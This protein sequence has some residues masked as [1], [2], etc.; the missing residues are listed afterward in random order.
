MLVVTDT[1]MEVGWLGW[2]LRPPAPCLVLVVKATYSLEEQGTCGLAEPQ[3]PLTGD[4]YVDD[5]PERSLVYDSD[6]AILK[7][8][9]EVLL[10][11]TCYPAGL[12]PNGPGVQSSLVQLR[13]GALRCQL[14]VLGDRWWNRGLLGGVSAPLPFRSMPLGWERAFG[15]P[16]DPRNPVGVG[17]VPDPHDAEGRV[18][19]PNI[20]DPARLIRGPK[21]R[22]TPAGLFPISKTWR[23]RT[24]HAG[25]YD[26][27]WRTMRYPWFPIDFRYDYFQAA[28]QSGPPVPLTRP[29]SRPKLDGRSEPVHFPV[30]NRRPR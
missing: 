6:F 7:P 2:S 10:R 4:R 14:A 15:G 22:P 19:L 30:K 5:D 18:K 9:G 1:A 16:E 29:T 28:P 25:R 24:Q 12:S 21:E 3:T 20:E 23:A 8:R 11:G 17:L 13:V 27:R 26:S